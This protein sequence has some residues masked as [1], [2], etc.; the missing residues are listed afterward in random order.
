MDT[1]P[2]PTEV[3]TY[4]FAAAFVRDTL[5]A[6]SEPFTSQSTVTFNGTTATVTCTGAALLDLL[7]R[8]TYY[9]DPRNGFTP[10]VRRTTCRSAASVLRAAQQRYQLDYWYGRLIPYRPSATAP[11]H[12]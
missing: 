7:G 3:R 5:E 11:T 8:A 10:D 9:N 2:E 1:T 4:R 6:A 12:K